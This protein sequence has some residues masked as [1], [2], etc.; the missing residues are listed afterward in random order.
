MAKARSG[1]EGEEL[2]RNSRLRSRKFGNVADNDA[3]ADVIDDALGRP[4][5]R[6]RVR[7][8]D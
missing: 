7:L 2:V 8:S 5:S 4:A 6:T 1:G 3:A